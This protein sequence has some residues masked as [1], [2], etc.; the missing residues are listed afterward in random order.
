MLRFSI[1]LVLMTAQALAEPIVG[2]ATVTDGDSIKIGNLSIR[3]EGIDAPEKNQSC[4]DEAGKVFDCGR[5]ATKTLTDLITGKEIKCESAG[6]DRNKRTLAFCSLPNG[7]EINA[8]L[9]DA[10]FA[11][12]FI[13]YSERYVENEANAKAAKAG[14]WSGTFNYPWCFRDARHGKP[15]RSH[16][17]FDVASPLP[18]PRVEAGTTRIDRPAKGEAFL[19]LLNP[20]SGQFDC[21]R[22]NCKQMNSCKEA[23]HHFSVC[24][25]HRLDGDNDGVPCENVCD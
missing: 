3:L 16:D 4:R 24:G 19:R 5:L 11:F 6:I 18:G 13:E 10:G 23:R 2:T 15:C 12:A 21:A 9:V 8:L 25:N 1:A 22:K 17:A 14:L 20:E 7:I